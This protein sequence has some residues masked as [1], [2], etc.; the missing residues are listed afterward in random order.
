MFSNSFHGK[1]GPITWINDEFWSSTSHA[2]AN[3]YTYWDKS[4]R[5]EIHNSVTQFIKTLKSKYKV[6][7]TFRP[8]PFWKEIRTH[9]TVYH[10]EVSC[11]TYSGA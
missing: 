6:V 2:L 4:G 10:K 8:S 3:L 1:S 7:T 5:E 11:C 9:K